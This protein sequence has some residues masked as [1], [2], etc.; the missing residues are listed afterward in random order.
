MGCLLFHPSIWLKNYNNNLTCEYC[1]VSDSPSADLV[2]P[3]I[4]YKYPHV[5]IPASLYRL[6]VK[7][8]GPSSNYSC[9][10]DFT[11]SPGLNK[12]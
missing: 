2:K 10:L 6:G 3:K 8:T 11:H 7:S 5:L 9:D 4:G 1:L 12:N